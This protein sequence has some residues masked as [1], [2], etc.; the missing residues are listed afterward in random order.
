[1]LYNSEMYNCSRGIYAGWGTNVDFHTLR[2]TCSILYLEGYGTRITGNVS[3][4]SGGW[5]GFNIISNFTDMTTIPI[6]NG[7]GVVA[8]TTGSATFN[9]SATGTYTTYWWSGDSDIRQ[10]YTKSNGRTKGGIFYAISGVSGT[11]KS[12][13][14]KLTR[15]KNYGKGS[16]V[17]VKVYGT[18]SAGKSG[19]PALSTEGYVLGTIDGGQTAEFALPAALATGLGNGT[20]KGIVLYADDT[21]ALHGK[22][23]STNFARFSADASLTITWTV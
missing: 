1:M 23:Y 9:P 16:A 10:G 22:T 14:L 8:P 12:A 7:S 17:Q 3:R 2:G 19:N 20:Y 21:T 6:D 18:T 4:P 13:I 11:V 15:L 5:S